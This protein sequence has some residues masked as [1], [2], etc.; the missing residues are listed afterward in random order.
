MSLMSRNKGK[1]GEREVVK[2]LQPVV[3][4]VYSAMDLEIPILQRNLMQSDRGGFDIAGLEWMALEV[5]RRETMA[6]NA[7]WVQTLKQARYD[8]VPVLLY[9]GNHEPW[10]ACLLGM[11]P[12][13]Y[14]EDWLQ[15]RVTVDL[16]DFLTW[17]RRRLHYELLS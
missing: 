2:L 17:F 5:K 11:L 1:A 15:A 12:M 7:W 13:G 16:P 8:Q 9:R 3:N 10:R 6:L 14:R 4:E